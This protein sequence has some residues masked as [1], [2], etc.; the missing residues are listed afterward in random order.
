MRCLLTHDDKD[1]PGFGLLESSSH[2]IVVLGFSFFFLFNTML[3]GGEEGARIKDVMAGMRSKATSEPPVWYCWR[4]Q[5]LCCWNTDNIHSV[6][7]HLA[8]ISLFYFFLR[9]STWKTADLVW[10]AGEA[11]S[12][13]CHDSAAT[14]TPLVTTIADPTFAK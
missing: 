8:G 13:G 5:L 1:L 11:P 10:R 14:I 7:F 12:E 6:T 4:L 9:R 3:T 2:G